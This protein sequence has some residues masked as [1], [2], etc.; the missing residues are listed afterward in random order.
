MCLPSRCLETD[1]LTPLIYRYLTQTA[2]KI[3]PHLLLRIP[4]T[5]CLPRIFLRGNLFTN[6]L[7]NSGCIYNNIYL[8]RHSF[9]PRKTNFCGLPRSTLFSCLLVHL[10]LKHWNYFDIQI[11][12][13][14]HFVTSCR[15]REGAQGALPDMRTLG[16]SRF[17]FLLLFFKRSDFN[18]QIRG[19]LF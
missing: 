8:D 3:Q 12:E 9:L 17:M 13:T 14:V 19:H 11:F 7:P 16:K 15:I 10:N 18:S 2:Y 1:C 5:D 4:E 6:T